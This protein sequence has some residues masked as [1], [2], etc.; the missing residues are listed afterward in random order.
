[1]YLTLTDRQR[2]RQPTDELLAGGAGRRRLKMTT[3][4]GGS[5]G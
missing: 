3:I 5:G 4:V 2:W 1:M